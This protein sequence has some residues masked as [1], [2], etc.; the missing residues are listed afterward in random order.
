MKTLLLGLLVIVIA[1]VLAWLAE[2]RAWNGG[3]CPRHGKPWHHFSFDSQGG[4]GYW[5]DPR[6]NS[7]V[8]TVW[9]SWPGVR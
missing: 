5:C 7:P 3:K 4:S 6:L 1:G 8:C 2:R 9:V